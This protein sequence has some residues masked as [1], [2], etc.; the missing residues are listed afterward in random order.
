MQPQNNQNQSFP[1]QVASSLGVNPTPA[2]TPPTTYVVT[3]P[4]QTFAQT[5]IKK[6]P[7][8]PLL[9]AGLGLVL[10][11]SAGLLVAVIILM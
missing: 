10:L 3:Q 8:I 9:Y 5:P 4:V 1:E 2:P 11:G 7:L 6:S